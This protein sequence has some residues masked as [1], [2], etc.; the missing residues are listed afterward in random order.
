VFMNLYG[1]ILYQKLICYSCTNLSAILIGIVSAFLR[2]AI[3]YK[4]KFSRDETFVNFAS[5][6][7]FVKCLRLLFPL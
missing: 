2:F 6:S 7:A 3:P 1:R 5:E 4:G